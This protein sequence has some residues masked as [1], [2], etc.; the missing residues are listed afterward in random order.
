MLR[1]YVVPRGDHAL[2]HDGVLVPLAQMRYPELPAMPAFWAKQTGVLT[3]IQAL[4]FEN[5]VQII[6]LGKEDV[7]YPRLETAASQIVSPRL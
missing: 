3:Y 1:G 2:F 4:C 7:A 5:K 6:C